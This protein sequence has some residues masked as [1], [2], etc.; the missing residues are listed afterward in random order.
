M[1]KIFAILDAIEA[2]HDEIIIENNLI[3]IT[4]GLALFSSFLGYLFYFG[5]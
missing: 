5:N 3:D 4:I 1:E 2:K